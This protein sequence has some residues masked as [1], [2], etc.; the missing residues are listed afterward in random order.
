MLVAENSYDCNSADDQATDANNN[1][2]G[3]LFIFNSFKYVVI[4]FF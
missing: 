1:N 4:K 2:S 3:I